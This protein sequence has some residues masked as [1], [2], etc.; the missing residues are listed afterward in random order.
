MSQA[1]PSAPAAAG[2]S[3]Q[4]VA[5][6]AAAGG[7]HAPGLT[8][9]AG[10][11]NCFL[12]VIIQCL[13]HCADFRAA[14]LAWPPALVGADPVVAALQGLLRDIDR[15]SAASLRASAVAGGTG[16]GAALLPR[17][18][19]VNPNRLREA[20]S[21]VPGQQ[22]RVSHARL[23][24][25]CVHTESACT[26]THPSSTRAACRAPNAGQMGEMNDAGEVLLTI[27]ERIRSVS[28][29]AAAVVDAVFGLS[30]Y[31]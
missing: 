22:F 16:G 31:E 26:C 24:R 19:S 8:N 5:A 18:G 14:A 17:R 27:Y 28:A 6:A 21:Q 29:Q 25:A 10:E 3:W 11:Y 20:L 7:L 30:V 12:N 15:E 13:W 1:A 4:Q 9:E 23:F 2:S